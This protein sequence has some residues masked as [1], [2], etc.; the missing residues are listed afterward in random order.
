M[1]YSFRLS[2]LAWL[3]EWGGPWIA[4]L[5]CYGMLWSA[6][7]PRDNAEAAY[8]F[9][10]PV[11]IWFHFRPGLRKCIICLLLAGWAYQIA[12]VG[13]MRHVSFGGM[14]VATFLLSLYHLVWFLVARAWYPRFSS[15]TF[16]VRFLVIVGLSALWV[17]I[18]WA[19]TLFTLGFPWCPLSVT[20]W[21]RPVLLQTALFGGGWTVSFFL[22]FF[23]L[24]IGSYLHHLLVRRRKAEGFF[25][26]SICPELYLGILLLM[27]MVYP[28]FASS[29]SP[30]V[31]SEK[32][33]R[34]GVCQPYLL[35]KWKEGRAVQHK[36]ILTQQ[37]EFL[38]LL[39]PDIILWPEASTPYPINLDPLWVEELAAKSGIPILAGSV[40][41]EEDISYN[42]MVYVD[43]AKGMNREWY[44]K[45]V[46]VPFG[47]YVPVPFHLIPGLD[48]MVGP[49]GNFSPGDRPILFDLPI[50]N[51]GSPTTVRAGAL[52][53]YE[54][55]FPAVSRTAVD[56]GA[57]L[58]LVSTNDAWFAEE[59]CAEQHAAHS[60]LRA[61]E[62]GLPI[63]R[64][65]NAGWSGWVDN[66]GIIGEVL[67][68]ESGSVYFRGASVMEVRIP[69]VNRPGSNSLGYQFVIFCTIL[70]VAVGLYFY[71]SSPRASV[72]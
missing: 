47:E 57:E 32:T 36:K 45:Q 13:W 53:C 19:R 24:C 31:Q 48:K 1:F 62:N 50:K 3:R 54:D 46:L 38:S 41:R 44:A 8:L 42:A 25:N 2:L 40:V 10:L 27:L 61:V 7:A 12:L 6:H 17:S 72:S 58:L 5:L 11:L 63:V 21:E 67:E 35:D 33:L 34:V 16:G 49:V 64:C 14:T 56:Y 39:E 20:Q 68:D 26:R 55:I 43:P 70:A 29:D 9:L 37:T 65:G 18:E 52:I 22:V 30:S 15:G 60:V 23:N 59:G 71:F 4:S 51:N 28:F 69:G 66:R